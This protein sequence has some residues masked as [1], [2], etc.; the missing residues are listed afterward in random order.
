M[1]T[2]VSVDTR[3]VR[4]PTS[5]QLDGSDA[6]NP[7][8]DYSAAY[9]V[10]RTDAADGLDGHGFVFTIGRGNDVQVAAH[11]RAREPYLVGQDVEDLLGDLGAASRL[12][13]HDSQLRWLG[14]EK[15]VMHMAIGAVV[16]ALWDL[17]AKRAGL[18]LWQLLAGADARGARRTRRLPLPHRRAHPRRGTRH[19]ARAPSPDAADRDGAAR[20]RRLPR[21]HHVARLARLRRREARPALPRGGRR[22]LHP[23]QAEG[24]R[25]PRRRRPPPAASRASACGDGHPASP[26]TP[27][28]AGTSPRRSSG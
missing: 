10:I 24:R 3:D 8:P 1:S 9:V 6:M 21:L 5:L 4:F 15:G 18:P 2:I 16:N 20:W 22:R 23:D 25:R 27:T 17:T 13:T 11:R 12:L 7:D 28:S 19:A 14:P 26:S